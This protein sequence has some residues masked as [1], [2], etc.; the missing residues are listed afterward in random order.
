VHE[1]GDDDPSPLDPSKKAGDDHDHDHAKGSLFYGLARG[2]AVEADRHVM[3]Q[4]EL[5]W[6]D[7]GSLYGDTGQLD[8]GKMQVGH[9]A[10]TAEAQTRAKAEAKRATKQ[11]YKFAQS[12]AGNEALFTQR[13][14]V[15]DLLN[16]VDLIISHPE[17]SVW[18]RP[19]VDG[20]VDAHP[21]EVARH[22]RLRNRVR[23]ARTKVS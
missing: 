15:R 16:I 5:M 4:V 22:I 1:I 13:P 14:A 17:D 20:Y 7:R 9:D 21:D 2:L 23:G 11:G 19:V 10:F 8:T 6:A 12:D 18:W 3:R